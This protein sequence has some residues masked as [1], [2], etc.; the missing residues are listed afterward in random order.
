MKVF[1]NGF[2]SKEATF[3]T[4][5]AV[6]V[7]RAVALMNTGEVHYPQDENFTGIVASYKDGYA[8]V[9]MRGYAVASFKNTVPTVGICKLKPSST[10]YM[11]LDET[12]GKPYT[13][14]GVDT[15]NKTIEFII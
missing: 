5:A 9:V 7:G 2:E 10:G 12:N 15:V 4:L 3:K 13:V 8:S 11:E 1:F 6:N 14:V